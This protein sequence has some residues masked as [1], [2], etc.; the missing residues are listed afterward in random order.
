MAESEMIA[1][2]IQVEFLRQ[3]LMAMEDAMQRLGC[4]GTEHLEDCIR[5]IRKEGIKLRE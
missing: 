3:C 1:M 2:E 4:I 5:Q